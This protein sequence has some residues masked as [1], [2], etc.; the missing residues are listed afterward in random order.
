M[1]PIKWIVFFVPFVFS[2]FLSPA[3][4]SADSNPKQ[5]DSQ[6]MVVETVNINRSDAQTMATVL[7]GIGLK[8]AESIVAYRTAKWRILR[9]RSR[10][11]VCGFRLSHYRSGRCPEC[12]WIIRKRAEWRY[13]ALGRT[14]R[15][16]AGRVPDSPH[17]RC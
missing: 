2:L 3:A 10:C 7:N 12:G 9:A 5:I 17:R 11:G 1:K 16:E 15:A 8:R 4:S 13:L 6:K 14:T